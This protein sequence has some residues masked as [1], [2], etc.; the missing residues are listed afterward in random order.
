MAEGAGLHVDA[1]TTSGLSTPE[2]S[3]SIGRG[4]GSRSRITSRRGS[5]DSDRIA[6]ENGIATCQH[7]VAD[8]FCSILPDLKGECS[9][10]FLPGRGS[11]TSPQCILG[12]VTIDA[13][14]SPNCVI[15]RGSHAPAPHA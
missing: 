4:I 6:L 1:L 9:G 12:T 15:Y 5:N 11:V 3:T 8:R 13:D 2:C 7:S 10:R 14:A